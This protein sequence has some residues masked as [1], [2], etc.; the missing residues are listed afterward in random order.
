MCSSMDT[1][2]ASW[3][4][5][6]R[7][8]GW[9]GWLRVVGGWGAAGRPV[10]ASPLGHLPWSHGLP[11]SGSSLLAHAVA[12]CLPAS[13]LTAPALSEQPLPHAPCPSR[14]YHPSTLPTKHIPR[15][16]LPGLPAPRALLLISFF[17]RL[18]GTERASSKRSR[19]T[20][21]SHS[22]SFRRRSGSR[23]AT[24][25]ACGAHGVQGSTRT[26]AAH[27]RK[28]IRGSLAAVHACCALLCGAQRRWRRVSV[29]APCAVGCGLLR[30]LL[31]H[32]GLLSGA[33]L[34]ALMSRAT[35]TPS[36]GP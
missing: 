34:D 29:F 10:R 3:R 21:R 33:T 26:C 36:A 18:T 9:L 4:S 11:S 15:R 12:R 32:A 25:A 6:W 5:G 28:S 16:L 27:R 17:P 30:G 14:L 20:S 7:L 2:S 35:A 31:C 22:A 13:V 1:S 24:L 8:D 19:L 23:G